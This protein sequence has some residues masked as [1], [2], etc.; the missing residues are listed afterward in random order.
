MLDNALITLIIATIIAGEAIAGVSGTPIQQAFQPTQQGIPKTTS[1]FLYKVGDVALGFP[2]RTDVWDEDTATM[3][4][5]ESQKYETTFQISAQSIQ[6]PLD[7]SQ[8]TASDILN[9]I[10]SILQSSDTIATFIAS[11]VGILRV[12]D[13]RN[14]SFSDDYARNEYSPSLDFV[15]EHTQTITS[16][17]P[18][19]ESV[20][21]ILDRV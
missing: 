5:T 6:D 10:R 3:I 21:F 18:V 15:I 4:H 20:D 7:Q 9:L 12:H 17:A 14:A 16:T 8:Y 13:I 19:V 11:G 2:S 1:A